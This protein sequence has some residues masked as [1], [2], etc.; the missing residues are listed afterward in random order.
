MERCWTIRPLCYGEFPDFSRAVLTYNCHFGE[1]V[2]SPILGWLLQ[3]GEDAILV[4]T[5]PSTPEAARPFHPAIRQAPH[6]APA[7]LLRALGVDPEAL[8]LVVLTHL[9]WDHCHN[10]ASFPAARVLVQAAELRAAVDP[11]ATQ[12]A[13]YEVGFP[14]LR[15]PWL[16]AFGRLVLLRGDADIA[17]G[18]RALLLPGHTPGLQGVLVDTAAGRYLIA[19]DGAPQAANLGEP[20]GVPIPP[21]IHV[22]V[23]DCLASLAR[24]QREAD[25]VLPGHD[26]AVLAHAVYP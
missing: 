7:A 13:T 14:G 20:G 2:T 25:V 3:A 24:M 15:P 19:S 18:V 12:R 17:P 16:A 9:H 11:V 22:D 21:G 1:T 5:G 4:D 6:Q 23:A 26:P 10:L 8:R